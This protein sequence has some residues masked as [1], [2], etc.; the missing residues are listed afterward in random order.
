MD[1]SAA[2]RPLRLFLVNEHPF[3]LDA[4]QRFLARE[5]WLAVVGVATVSSDWI[6]AVEAARPDVLVVDPAWQRAQLP[7]LIRQCRGRLPQ[8]GVVV[9]MLEE[10]SVTQE[11][12]QAAGAD[13][14]VA[15]EHTADDL[16]A[17]IRVA[18]HRA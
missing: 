16:L 8:L 12:A 1:N 11:L 15:K 13:A 2:E 5:A 14:F 10:G 7:E 9:L 6:G 17:A 3:F 18:A 4:M